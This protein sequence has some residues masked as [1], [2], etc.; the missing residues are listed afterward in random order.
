MKNAE[1]IS[2]NDY[3]VNSTAFFFDKAGKLPGA[4]RAPLDSVTGQKYF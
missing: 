2:R 1:V 4:E 3:F